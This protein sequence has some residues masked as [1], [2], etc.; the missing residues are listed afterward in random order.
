MRLLKKASLYAL[1][2]LCT[3]L[4]RPGEAGGAIT[5]DLKTA[6]DRVLRS[7]RIRPMQPLTKKERKSLSVR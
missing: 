3:V 1:I 6:V 2:L 5:D 7:C 4:V